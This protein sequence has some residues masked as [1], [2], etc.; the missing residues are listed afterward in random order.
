MIK[1]FK[2]FK[3]KKE[4]SLT[5]EIIQTKDAE[6][7]YNLLYQLPNP[8][9]ILRKTGKGIKALRALLSNYQVGT[10]V[11]SRKAGVLAKK[12]RIEKGDCSDKEYLFWQDVF[13]FFD[14]HSFIENILEAP[15]F[16]YVPF[17]IKLQK[18]GNF[19]IP[20]KAEAK[21]QEWFYFNQNGDLFF[22]S[23]S[24]G[25]KIIDINSPKIILARHRCL[26]GRQSGDGCD[27][28]TGIG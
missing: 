15:L 20:I 9:V 18:D 7:M 12:W 14:F 10:C 16:G 22:N 8:D 6:G 21:P 11:E 2:N 1:I 24:E 19:I 3:I 25:G 13:K 4:K 28:R 5:E 17:E 27:F 26:F 23:K